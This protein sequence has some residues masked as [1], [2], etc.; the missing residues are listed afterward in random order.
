MLIDEKDLIAWLFMMEEDAT[1]DYLK[2]HD[3][4]FLG[5]SMG[6]S[7]TRAKIRDLISRSEKA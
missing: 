2:T 1:H 7:I 4:S 3:D 5:E 6:Y